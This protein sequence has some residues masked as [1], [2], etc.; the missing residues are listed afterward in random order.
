M[1]SNEDNL[2]PGIPPVRAET[3]RDTEN[4][5]R[6]DQP[7]LSIAHMMV[8]T[9]GC[10]VALVVYRVFFAERGP[11]NPIYRVTMFVYILTGGTS[12]FG[13]AMLCYFRI[14]RIPALVAP[15][16][17]LVLGNALSF[18]G[19][20]LAQA[21][22]QWIDLINPYGNYYGYF[23]VSSIG[24]AAVLVVYVFAI[25]RAPADWGRQWK[26]PFVFLCLQQAIWIWVYS[27]RIL[28]R[29]Y[30]GLYWISM[31]MSFLAMVALLH[32]IRQKKPW[33][34]LHTLGVGIELLSF[35]LMAAWQV[36][37]F[38]YPPV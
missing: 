16:H 22:M 34:W 21:A 38:L 5:R 20:W 30:F 33:N 37:R 32:C 31:F 7:S 23:L 3:Q 11:D 4:S 36:A 19:T 6:V 14:R 8:W 15:G 12:L 17:W 26:A 13:L 25:V 27:S 9:L 2:N 29:Q 35:P 28:F 18:I 10:A 24:V 1:S